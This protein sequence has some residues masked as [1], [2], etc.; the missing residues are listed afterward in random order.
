MQFSTASYGVTEGVTSVTITV[1]R[2]GPI[3]GVSTVD[4]TVNNA[5][6]TQRGDF[7]YAS[8]TVVFS[9]NEASK[10]FPVLISEDGYL[11]G[12][13][14]ASLS[15]T[16]PTGA[17]L[18]SPGTATLQ[19]NDND[20]ADAA[21]NPIDDAGTFVCQHY[22]DFLNR[23][24]DSNGQTF[25]TNQITSCGTDTNCLNEKRTNVSA[26]FF[27]SIEFQNT[28]YFAFRFYRASF[29][30]SA[31]RP[32]G[33]PR[34]LEFLRDEQTLQNG[35]VVGQPN[36]EAFLEQNKQGFALDWV[37]RADFIAEYPTTM[38]RDEYIDK[39]FTA[40]GRDANHAGTQPGAVCLRQRWQ[41]E[42]EASQG[43][44]GGGR[45]RRGLQRTIQPGVRAD[46]ILWLP[47]PQSRTARRTTTSR[48]TTS[49][50]TR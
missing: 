50:L 22:H 23:Q 41:F 9:A 35:V 12:P 48:A 13:E 40:I 2:T 14:S 28:G 25:W 31:Q 29:P 30:D 11:E 46:A 34:Y 24:A 18:G 20:T 21:S 49:G 47:A 43:N 16:N 39:L 8:G 1:T 10:T 42:R 26:A 19:I 15:L 38:T 4:Y 27:L 37:D 7:T 3:S 33:V 5:S 36:W 6:A 44:P 32:R 45:Y 17:T